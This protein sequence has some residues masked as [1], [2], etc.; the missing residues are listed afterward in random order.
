MCI[1]SAAIPSCSAWRRILNS[2]GC[3][4]P[5][6]RSARRSACAGWCARRSALPPAASRGTRT[7]PPSAHCGRPAS[8]RSVCPAMPTAHDLRVLAGHQQDARV[9]RTVLRKHALAEQRVH[10]VAQQQREHRGVRRVLAQVP[11]SQPTA[12]ATPPPSAA[13]GRCAKAC[14]ESASAC[15]AASAPTF[16]SALPMRFSRLLGSDAGSLR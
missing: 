2:S 4:A 15:D 13:R 16:T 5:A 6:S 10:N 3:A 14:S 7:P 1:C 11:A 9:R 12:T 8:L